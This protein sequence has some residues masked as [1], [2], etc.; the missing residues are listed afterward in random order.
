MRT[1]LLELFQWGLWKMVTLAMARHL[2][3]TVNVFL[4]STD[5]LDAEHSEVR[6]RA[7]ALAAGATDP[8]VIAE[9]CFTWVRDAIAHSRD[10]RLQPVTCAASDVLRVGS[11]YC[12]AKS[13][14]L[15]ALLRANGVPAGLGYQRLSR[16][17]DGAPYC[18]HGLVVVDLPGVGWYRIDPRGNRAGIDARFEPPVEHLAFVPRLPGEMDLPGVYADP[19]PVVVDTLRSCAT[20]DEVFERLPDVEPGRLPRPTI[21]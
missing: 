12:Y 10:H 16:D 17:D 8:A 20:A 2:T 9:R 11:G 5:V 1:A 19:L 4:R 7:D 6:A 18:L 21:A 15:A 13:H 3:R 14:L